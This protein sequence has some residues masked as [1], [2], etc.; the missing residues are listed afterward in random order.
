MVTIA[1]AAILL[2]FAV[3]SLTGFVQT[4]KMAAATNQFVTTLNYARAQAVSLRSTVVVCK[5]SNPF[6]ST[7]VCDTSGTASGY[8]TGWVLFADP[9]AGATPQTSDASASVIRVLKPDAANGLTI[10]GPSAGST[11]YRLAFTPQGMASTATAGASIVLC[12]QRQW[13]SSGQF[14]R[15]VTI[16]Q[17]GRIASA[18]GNASSATTCTP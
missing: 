5:T 9:G 2:A 17:S 13:K 11:F 18:A 16:S 1:V 15:V 4:N 12:D 3:P 14:A 10:R 7:P 6:P 8:E